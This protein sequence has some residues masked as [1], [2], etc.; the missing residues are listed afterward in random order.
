[1]DREDSAPLSLRGSRPGTSPGGESRASPTFAAD[2]ASI[3]KCFPAQRPA[4]AV[5]AIFGAGGDLTKRLVVP[6]LYNRAIVLEQLGRLPEALAGYDRV[7]ALRADHAGARE[8][9]GALR[10]ELDRRADQPASPA[11][12][13]TPPASA[14]QG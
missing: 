1:M 7:L 4:P 8:N 11:D 13:S 9:H 10:H 6:A 14:P 5:M 12:P 3:A 2:A